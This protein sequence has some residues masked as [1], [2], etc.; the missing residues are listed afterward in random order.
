MIIPVIQHNIMICPMVSLF[1]T[2]NAIANNV[3]PYKQF[4]I[5]SFSLSIYLNLVYLL[6]FSM[7][8]SHCFTL[9]TGI[10]SIPFE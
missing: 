2:K 7:C 10:N 8:S 4:I 6:A 1:I 5:N 3:K 9:K